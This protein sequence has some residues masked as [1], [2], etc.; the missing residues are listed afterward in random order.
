MLYPDFNDLIAYKAKMNSFKHAS[1]RCVKSSAA[2]NNHSTFRGRG[3]EFDS[4]RQYVPGDDIRS[5]DWRVT[6]RTGLPHLKLFREERER[7]I[8]LGVDMNAAMR[9][10]TKNTFKSVQAAHAAS[11]LGWRGLEQ[12]HGVSACLFGDVLRGIQVFPPKNTGKSFCT[13]LKTFTQ[14]SLEKHSISIYESLQHIERISRTGSLIYLISDFMVLDGIFQHDAVLSR[15]NRRC[16]VVFIA[17]NDRSDH[18]IHPVGT[19][20]FCMD[21]ANKMFVNTDSIAGREAYTHLWNQNRQQL[22][23]ITAKFKIPLIE[24]S[25]ESDIQRDLAL[26][27]K[28]IVKRMRQ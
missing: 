15:L 22:Y 1:K 24:L 23:G 16:D 4:V 8:L 5:I 21:H 3:L 26:G 19:I 12:H 25:T 9:F 18:C 27:L 28:S 14:P 13:L 7:E 6:A 11:F 2:G 20:G 10:G 17:I